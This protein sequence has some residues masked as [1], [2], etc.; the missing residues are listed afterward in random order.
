M[1]GPLTVWPFL[2][3]G[4]TITGVIYPDTIEAF[5]FRQSDENEKPDIKFQQDGTP[6]EFSDVVRDTLKR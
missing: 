1:C 4:N 2:F 3:T 5:C 6:S